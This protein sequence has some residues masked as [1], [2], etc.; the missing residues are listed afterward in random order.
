MGVSAACR[1]TLGPQFRR[2]WGRLA[3][4]SRWVQVSGVSRSPQSR[5]VLGAGKGQ[6]TLVSL[7]FYLISLNY[8]LLHGHF[9]PPYSFFSLL[10]TV[11]QL[12]Y[13]P[14]FLSFVLVKCEQQEGRDLCLFCSL[15]DLQGRET[16]SACIPGTQLMFVD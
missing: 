1:S 6:K 9:L 5:T 3:F 14:I 16:Q 7:L 13:I 15:P 10:H 11:Y 8:G 2:R 4:F 12:I